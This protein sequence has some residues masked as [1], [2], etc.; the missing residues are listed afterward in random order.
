MRTF[1]D[2]EP[3]VWQRTE[4]C[5]VWDADGREY[6]DLYAGFAVATVGYCHPTVT[7]AICR[8]AATMTHCPS[9][10]PSEVRASLYER[11]VGL[12]PP[13][14]GRVL[15]A[16][17]GAL[18]NETAVQ[19]ARAATGRQGVITFAGTY[20]GRTVGSVRYAGKH[21]YREQLG[22]PGDAQFLPYP[23]PY[24]SAWADGRDPG[25]AVLAL[26]EE[27]L[28]DPASG[29][30]TPACVLV[31]PVQGNGGVVI[32]PDGFLAGLRRICD[33]NGVLLLFD[34]IQ[35]G[36][37]RTGRLW[38][39]D[40]E[41]VVPDLMTVGKGIGGGLA[42]GAVLGR[43]DV[44]TTWS[45]DAVTST[46]LANA[47]N[48]AAGCAALDVLRDE[49]LVDR[50]ATLGARALELLR[51]G[52]ADSGHV[53]DVRG[54]GLFVGVE[55]VADRKTR[56]P[57]AD[58]ALRTVGTLRE[59]GVLVG[60]GGRHGNVIKLSPPLVI[61]ENDLDAGLATVLEVLA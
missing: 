60:R 47:L 2:P 8:Q 28:G 44:M 20:V 53:G 9:A 26:L 6:L 51:A 45:S 56:T 13:G 55:L 42:L 15:L 29:V 19:L 11:L 3:L 34:E 38:A 1:S 37:G 61:A 50:S 5:R 46:F 32:P 58:L 35:S 7:A 54:R 16:V 41:G 22:V 24:R 14:L 48:A 52:L 25:P 49:R 39:C 21:A 31:E 12:A 57:A 23:D 36:F 4:G 30:E 18:A 43:E 17:T 33:E 27:L 40:H 59:R 10:A